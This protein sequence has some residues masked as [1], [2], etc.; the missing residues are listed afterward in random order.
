MSWSSIHFTPMQHGFSNTVD[1]SPFAPP[2]FYRIAKKRRPKLSGFSQ[3]E[4]P[5]SNF[6]D[7]SSWSTQFAI[8]M[9]T[10]SG[11]DTLVSFNL[12]QH[13]EPAYYRVYIYMYIY[14][15]IHLCMFKPPQ[16]SQIHETTSGRAQFSGLEAPGRGCLRRGAGAEAFSSLGGWSTREWTTGDSMVNWLVVSNI[17]YFP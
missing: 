1:D 9:N 7:L 17:F 2:N 15:Y 3:V 6:N 4:N 13:T 14:L 11:E 12:H 10:T 8:S 5:G 16:F